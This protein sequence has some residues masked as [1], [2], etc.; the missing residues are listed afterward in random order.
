MT[1]AIHSIT[2]GEVR[3]G[4]RFGVEA[5]PSANPSRALQIVAE[6]AHGRVESEQ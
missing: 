4:A 5:S 1:G 2:K 3:P 6:R